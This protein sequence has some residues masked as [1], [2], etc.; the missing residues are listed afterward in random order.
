MVKT[1]SKCKEEKPYS[2]FYKDKTRKDGLEYKCNSCQKS[3]N[4]DYYEANKEKCNAQSKAWREANK[5]KLKAY[6][7]AYYEANKDR[8][9]TQTKAYRKANKEKIKAKKK[10]YQE[11]NKDKLKTYNKA[12][13]EVNKDIIKAKSKA[14]REANKEKKKALDKAYYEANK[15]K[16]ITQAKAY[17][18]ANKE[19][20]KAY[21]NSYRK[22][23]KDKINA[24][25][26]AYQKQRRKTNPLFR[27]KD[28]LRSRTWN[29]FKNKGYRKN[30]KTQEMLGV[31]WEVAKKHIERQFKKG[32]NWDNYGEWHIDH[33]IPL[34]SANTEERLKELCH[35]SN[36]QPLWAENNISKSDRIINQQTLLRI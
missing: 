15:D 10:A 11:A 28:N 33:I 30:T 34:A 18:E 8:I 21:N 19:K 27:L 35:Y 22:A 12:W 13:R 1:C 31:D 5:E 16:I 36:L 26:N 23:N 2:E 25:K 20:R 29:A 17:G 24:Y 6:R 4:K 7:K 3:Y 9:N 32:M 14:W